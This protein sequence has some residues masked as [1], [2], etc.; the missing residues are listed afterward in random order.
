M[1]SWGRWLPSLSLLLPEPQNRTLVL[2]FL[3]VCERSC[4]KVTTNPAEI[5]TSS[6]HRKITETDN[7]CCCCSLLYSNDAMVFIRFFSLSSLTVASG[8]F[9]K[10]SNCVHHLSSKIY[11]KQMQHSFC[12]QC[13]WKILHVN[14]YC[15]TTAWHRNVQVWKESQLH[16]KPRGIL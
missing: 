11:A 12:L 5:H 14:L 9:R 13:V 3:L 4:K 15:V 7:F 6:I 8:M 16:V 1:W 10:G 2:V